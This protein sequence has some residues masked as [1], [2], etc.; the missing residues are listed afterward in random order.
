[1]AASCLLHVKPAHKVSLKKEETSS[2]AASQ[3][4]RLLTSQKKGTAN[5]PAR[6][7]VRERKKERERLSGKF[8]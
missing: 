1:M 5:S 6:V 4:A 7:S 8:H 3:W 2:E